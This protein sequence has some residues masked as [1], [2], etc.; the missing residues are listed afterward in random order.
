MYALKINI[1]FI[2]PTYIQLRLSSIKKKLYNLLYQN[3]KY[4]NK[5]LWILDALTIIIVYLLLMSYILTLSNHV[6]WFESIS[7]NH[8]VTTNNCFKT[9]KELNIWLLTFID[10]NDILIF[11]HLEN[12]FNFLRD[13]EISTKEAFILNCTPFSERT[14]FAHVNE[15]ASPSRGEILPPRG[16]C[17][18]IFLFLCY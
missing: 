9:C 11:W 14:S 15:L 16:N 7:V 18:C 3:T 17:T 10:F 12:T 5:E 6:H 13:N 8:T 2:M 1:V 4:Q